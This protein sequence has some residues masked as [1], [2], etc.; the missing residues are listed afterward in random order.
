[1]VQKRRCVALAVVETGLIHR[2]AD[3]LVCTVFGVPDQSIK[4]PLVLLL[5]IGQLLLIVLSFPAELFAGLLSLL[6][7]GLCLLLKCL[8]CLEHVLELRLQTCQLELVL[9][10][11][12]LHLSGLLLFEVL[13]GPKATFEEASREPMEKT[14]HVGKFLAACALL[15]IAQH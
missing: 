12:L 1:M 2:L 13:V 8:C 11:L 15:H 14:D 4:Q 10:I 3:G 6:S 5:Q 9:F 7:L